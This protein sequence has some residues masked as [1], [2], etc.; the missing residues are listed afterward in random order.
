MRAL[1]SSRFQTSQG[2][3]GRVAVP[4][5]LLS[6]LVASRASSKPANQVN[7]K[8]G[9]SEKPWLNS[10]LERQETKGLAHVEDQEGYAAGTD[11]IAAAVISF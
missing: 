2:S 7:L 8:L 4:I 1:E 10:S 11:S 5:D 3:S 9:R 6:E